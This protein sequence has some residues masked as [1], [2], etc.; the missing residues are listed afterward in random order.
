MLPKVLSTDDLYIIVAVIYAYFFWRVISSPTVV[1]FFA[2]LDRFNCSLSEGSEVPESS[3]EIKKNRKEER[4]KNQLADL[5]KERTTQIL[6]SNERIFHHQKNNLASSIERKNISSPKEQL[7]F[8]NRMKEL[9][10]FIVLYPNP[11][12][13]IFA[14]PL[15]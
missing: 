13:C 5:K 6:R 8:Y 15:S 2:C 3:P 11:A 14:P 9:Y 7:R 4:R 1:L 10:L 12:S